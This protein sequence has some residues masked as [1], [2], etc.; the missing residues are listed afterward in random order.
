MRTDDRMEE[1][2]MLII[3]QPD[4]PSHGFAQCVSCGYRGAP[5][6][7]GGKAST[8]CPQCERESEED[9][10]ALGDPPKL[11]VPKQG[12]NEPCLCGSGLKAKKCCL[13]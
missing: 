3:Y 10:W 1:R 6:Y 8:H 12:R 9:M 7:L 4:H 11:R 2:G 13:K 5:T